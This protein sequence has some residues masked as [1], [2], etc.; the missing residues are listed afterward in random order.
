MVTA[1][2]LSRATVH[3][4]AAYIASTGHIPL[5]KASGLRLGL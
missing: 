3:A 4:R 5:R 2:P 1:R